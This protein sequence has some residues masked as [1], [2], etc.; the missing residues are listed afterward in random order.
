[1]RRLAAE[2][3]HRET[4]RLGASPHGFLNAVSIEVMLL[5]R[6]EGDMPHLRT[7]YRWIAGIISRVAVQGSMPSPV[8]KV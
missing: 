1:M 7:V 8:P 3:E 2:I 4:K 6:E 5:V